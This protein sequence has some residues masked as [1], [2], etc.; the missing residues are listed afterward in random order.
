[1]AI[2]TREAII[3]DKAKGGRP[4]L[5]TDPAY[6]EVSG[7]VASP[8]DPNLVRMVVTMIDLENDADDRGIPGDMDLD[9]VWSDTNAPVWLECPGCDVMKFAHT[10]MVDDEEPGQPCAV[11]FDCVA[12]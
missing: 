6:L 12:D 1:M 8:F 11:C 3:V 9:L 5:D 10:Y 2:I 4:V 7:D